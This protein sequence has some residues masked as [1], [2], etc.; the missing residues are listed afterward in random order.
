MDENST[1]S[2]EE[3]E[4]LALR[5]HNDNGYWTDEDMDPTSSDK[6]LEK[7]IVE[8]GKSNHSL[9]LL[10]K[11]SEQEKQERQRKNAM[12]KKQRSF[13]D[14]ARLLGRTKNA[15]GLSKSL[16]LYRGSDLAITHEN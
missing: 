12:R 14:S 5:D 7:K 2:D 10:I 1:K 11:K 16:S 6:N 9:D 3:Y 8:N 15:R 4:D 13:S